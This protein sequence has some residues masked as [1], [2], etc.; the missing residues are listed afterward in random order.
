[1]YYQI[2]LHLS[3]S[4]GPWAEGLV[5][6]RKLNSMTLLDNEHGLRRIHSMFRLGAVHANVSFDKGE[7]G[8]NTYPTLTLS[9]R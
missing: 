7:H 3:R 6:V 8:D 2:D 1:M 4:R 5:A 9:P